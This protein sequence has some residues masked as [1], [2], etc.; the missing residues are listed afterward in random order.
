VAP[1]HDR[2]RH[3]RSQSYQPKPRCAGRASRSRNR[4]STP[5]VAPPTH[6]RAPLPREHRIRPAPS[7]IWDHLPPAAGEDVPPRLAL[8]RGRGG[9][10]WHEPTTTAGRHPCHSPADDPPAAADAAMAV[11]TDDAQE[12][13][14]GRNAPPPP[15]LLAAPAR[16]SGQLAPTAAR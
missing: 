9:R 5:D 6:R 4:R 12:P 2:R 10:A 13:R 7:R 15:S 16:A 1:S 8:S 3:S 14:A 11:T